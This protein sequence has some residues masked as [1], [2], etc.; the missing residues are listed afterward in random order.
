M[1]A[2]ATVTPVRRA[3][4]FYE[5]T[6][7]KKVVM[8]ATG[9]LLF[10]YVVAHLAGNLQVFAGGGPDGPINRYAHLLHSAG[11]ML[12]AARAVLLLAVGLHIIA[13]VQLWLLNRAARP[14]AYHKKDDVPAAYAARTM[15]WSGVI[16]AAF[17]VFHVLHLTTGDVVPLATLPDGGMDVYANIVTG[18]SIWYVSLAY[19]VAVS[20]L[21]LHLYH[22]IYSMFQS[23]GLNHPRYSP[24]LKRIAEVFAIVLT[25]GYISIPAAV[26]AGILR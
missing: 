22:G 12:W 4:R 11:G 13:A 24:R 23:I 25:A 26:L 5:A 17:I 8:A 7:G 6:N 14:V 18:F 15:K 21:G 9:V 20:L 3:I 2:T 10:G 16:I 1:S 19:I